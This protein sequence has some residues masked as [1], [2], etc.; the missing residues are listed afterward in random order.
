[1]IFKSKK[2]Y[3][4]NF[5]QENTRNSKESWSKID[6]MLKNDKQRHDNIYA[7]KNGRVIAD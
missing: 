1:M 5:F 4:S 3:L 7:I 2:N 6:E